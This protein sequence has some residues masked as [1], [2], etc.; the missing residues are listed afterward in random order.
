MLDREVRERLEMGAAKPISAFSD[1]ARVDA[2]KRRGGFVVAVA[3][4]LVVVVVAVGIAVL[5]PGADTAHD[6]RALRRASALAPYEWPRYSNDET[7][8]SFQYPPDWRFAA[9]R[10]TPYLAD[11]KEIVSLGTRPLHYNERD[12]AQIPTG[13]LEQVGP[14]DAFLSIQVRGSGTTG[15]NPRPEVFNPNSGIDAGDTEIPDCSSE[16]GDIIVRFVPFDDAGRGLYAFVATGRS[17]TPARQAEPWQILNS[18]TVRPASV[19]DS[20][21][22][23]APPYDD[24]RERQRGVNLELR[25]RGGRSR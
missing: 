15:Y 17:A 9:E 6:D 4:G 14:T 12:C 2:A 7:G 25:V 10:L 3:A 24:A 16:L 18:L 21:E 19:P 8:I 23:T 13:A 22:T 20:S 1:H 5:R 11:P